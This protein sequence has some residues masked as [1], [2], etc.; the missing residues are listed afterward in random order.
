[1]SQDQTPADRPPEQPPT[2]ANAASVADEPQPKRKKKTKKSSSSGLSASIKA[3]FTPNAISSKTTVRTIGLISAAIVLTWWSVG[4]PR[5]IPTPMQIVQSFADLVQNQGLL[6]ELATS[7]ILNIES[8]GAATVA[9]LLLA[10]LTVLAG[11]KPSVAFVTKM[12]FLSLTGLTFVFGMYA[13]GHALKVWM[14]AFSMTTFF[15]TSTVAVIAEIPQEEWDDARTL[16]MTPWQAAIEVAVFGTF[17]KMLEALRQNAAIAWMM[18]TT[19]EGIIRT[20]GGIGTLL[21]NENRHFR[22]DAVF[23]IQ[24]TIMIV[25]L[26]QDWFIGWLRKQICPWMDEEA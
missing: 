3:A 7:I 20:E 5:V 24:A 13:G 17:D 21:L 25:G 8:I 11:F 1:M 14:L 15:A 12:R 26:L 22:M 16:R 19:V 10:Y 18:L 6:G 23:A 2:A 4:A 9:S